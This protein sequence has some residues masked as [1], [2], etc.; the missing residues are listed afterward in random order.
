MRKL[1][2]VTVIFLAFGSIL[3]AACT[4]STSRA[5][6][7]SASTPGAPV[8]KGGSP[9]SGGGTPGVSVHMS[10]TNFEEKSV[11]LSKGSSLT[12]VD[13]TDSVHIIQNGTWKDGIVEAGVE[14]G[15]L[16][17]DQNFV[18]NDTHQIGPFTTAGTFKL[19]CTVHSGMNLT[20]I[21]K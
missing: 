20:V 10:D 19:F 21:V 13:D 6:S 17:V 14:P 5:S 18:G 2:I 16:R 11:T 9:Q 3:L 1:L 8:S 15:A 4:S 12:L 7:Q